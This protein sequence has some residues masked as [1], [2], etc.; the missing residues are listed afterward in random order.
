MPKILVID[1]DENMRWALEKALT[2]D[3]HRVVTRSNGTL[4]LEAVLGESP[5]LVLCDLKMPDISGMDLLARL[6]SSHPALPVIM[7]TGYGTVDAAV[8]AMKLGA[9][10]FII[11]P[12][13]ID[14]VK[15]SVRKALGYEKLKDEVRF[16]RQEA[17]QNAMPKG[18][19][20]SSPPMMRLFELIKQV[21]STPATV[22]IVGESGTGKELVAQAIHQL[23][24]RRDQP[25][26]KVNCG[27]IPEN[28]LESELFGHEKG[29]FTG[30][31]ARKPG[32]FERADQGTIFLDEIGEISMVMQVKLLRVLQ[33]R[34]IERVGGTDTIKVDVRVIAATN[35]D[36]AA[37]VQSGRFREDLY[38]RLNVVPVA[39]PA[40]RERPEDIPEL[41]DSFVRR[42]S[43]ELGKEGMQLSPETLIYLQ[44]YHWPGNVRELQNIMER[45]V[46]LSTQSAII[47]ELLPIEVLRPEAGSATSIRSTGEFNIKLPETGIDLE[48]VERDLIRQALES[49]EGNQTKAAKLLGIS[50]YT[51]IYRLEKYGMK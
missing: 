46:I 44:K 43:G 18:I 48:G 21:A 49:V 23:S 19:I 37:E 26:I 38:Y 30:A 31:V 41:A 40:L 24:P 45:A 5:D 27:A 50:R 8:Q 9:A 25:L 14:A 42:F 15:M 6:S 51:L 22:L 28:L 16:W 1:D 7:I 3:G 35:K 36:L 4:G 17:M 29:A 11:K 13:D 39:V 47:P 34:E 12:F 20:G 10:D 32:R 2:K 33:E